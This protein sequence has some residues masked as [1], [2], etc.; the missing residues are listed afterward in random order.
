MMTVPETADCLVADLGD[1]PKFFWGGRS[2]AEEL[3][4]G[5]NLFEQHVG[6]DLNLA[7]TRFCRRQEWC[8]FLLHHNLTHESRGCNSIDVHRQR[9]TFLHAEG[10]RV[11]NDIK[12]GGITGANLD[13]QRRIMDAPKIRPTVHG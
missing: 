6:A 3:E 10:G 11:D 12:P 4:I 5:R 9:I 7:A 2:K 8:D 13:L 1:G